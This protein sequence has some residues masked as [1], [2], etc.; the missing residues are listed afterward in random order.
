M[1]DRSSTRS[2]IH[3][4][5]SIPVVDE[6]LNELHDLQNQIQDHH[7]A[8]QLLQQGVSS[9]LN[10]L[11]GE[12]ELPNGSNQQSSVHVMKTLSRNSNMGHPTLSGGFSHISTSK[13]NRVQIPSNLQLICTTDGSQIDSDGGKQRSPSPSLLEAVLSKELTSMSPLSNLK[14]HS[15]VDNSHLSNSQL[16]NSQFDPELQRSPIP[17][18]P[19]SFS[20]DINGMIAPSNLQLNPRISNSQLG[21]VASNTQL[22][23]GLT[24]VQLESRR[25][26]QAR[27]RGRRCGVLCGYSQGSGHRG[28]VPR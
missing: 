1:D 3:D 24:N 19:N 28:L 12:G 9:S 13:Q 5:P 8:D 15:D 7:Q 11:T 23:P 18:L 4:V 20:K 22:D 21:N 10:Q 26:A 25:A 27:S 6:L 14:L 16:S 17:S 2:V